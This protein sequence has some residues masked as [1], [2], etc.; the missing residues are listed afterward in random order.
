MPTVT[1]SMITGRY[2]EDLGI[3]ANTGGFDPEWPTVMKSIRDGGYG[4]ASIGKTHYHGMPTREQ[5]SPLVSHRL[6]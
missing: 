2:T 3:F 5:A 4:I 6:C 1:R